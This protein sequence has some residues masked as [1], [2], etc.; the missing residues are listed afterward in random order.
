M[1]KFRLLVKFSRSEDP[2]PGLI[3][4][5][6][7]K[8]E[9]VRLL[10]PVYGIARDGL[11]DFEDEVEEFCELGEAYDRRDKTLSSGMAGRVG[12]GF[13]TSLSPEILF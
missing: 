13:T 10:A 11:K 8:T 9:R 2:T 5:S 1:E 6:H 12:F 4:H 7:P 3:P